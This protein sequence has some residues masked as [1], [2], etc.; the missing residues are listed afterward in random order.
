MSTRVRPALSEMIRQFA[1][2]LRQDHARDAD[3]LSAFAHQQDDQAF[4]DLVA[5]HGP[6]VWGVC[7]RGLIDPNDAEDAFQATFL[8]LARQAGA[9][10]ERAR[11]H[12]TLAGWLYLTAQRIAHNL[13]R[14]QA[15]RC[16]HEQKAAAD[17]SE[18]A[19]APASPAF[20]LGGVLDEELGQLPARFREPLVLC[21]FQGKT[22][23][24]AA[25]QLGCPVGTVSGRLARACE[26]LR[27]RLARRGVALA[28]GQVAVVLAAAGSTARAAV[29]PVPAR[30]ADA[31]A[32]AAR[33]F[34][35]GD[36][37]GTAAG[38]LA[39]GVP[40]VR[41]G[42]NIKFV[43][44][45]AVAFLGVTVAAAVGLGPAP[46]PPADVRSASP[47]EVRDGGHAFGDP[48]PTGAIARLGTLR[49][50]TGRMGFTSSV[51]F[52]PGAKS[53]LSAH[54]D[55]VVH[56]WD[57]VTGR[58][59]PRLD[60]PRL[61]TAVSATPD[62]RRL[63]G[64]GAS[65]VW[66]WDL[67]ANPP[68]V[69][70]KTQQ[71]RIVRGS[72]AI[73]PNGRLVAHGSVKGTV[74]LLDAATGDELRTF[75]AVGSGLT[76]APDSM[77]LAAWSHESAVNASVA[78]TDVSVWNV[79]DGAH[80]YTLQVAPKGGAVSAVAFSPDGT[81]VA[82]AAGDRRLRLWNAA[83]GT[84]RADLTADADPLAYVGFQ[85]DGTLIEAGGGRVRF[86]DTVRGA[87][88]RP[89]V[90]AEDT[91]DAYLLSGDGTLLAR[92]GLFGAGMREVATGREIGA[93]A[94]M[95]DGLVHAVAFAPDGRSVVTAAYSESA[96]GSLYL[97]DATDG[98]LRG[99]AGTGTGHI[100]WGLDIAPDG[101][102]SVASVPLYRNPAPRTRVMTWAEGL[103]RPPASYPLP[104]GTRCGASSPDRRYVAAA[105]GDRVVFCDRATGQEVRAL[106]IKCQANSL[107]FSADGS[108]V[109]VL[110]VSARRVTVCS[111]VDG[112]QTAW[113][114]DDGA[115]VQFSL[116]PLALSPDG[117]LFAVCVAGRD[118]R[119]RV[120]ETA[121]GAEL[122]Q[123]DAR[124]SGLPAP[125]FV[126]SPDGRTLAA[127]G[128]DGT[129]RV[130]E[131]ATG[132]ERYRFSGHRAGVFSVAYSPDSRRVASASYD[133]TALVW[134]VG[135]LPAVPKNR[136]A[137][138]ELW[139]ALTG[140]EAAPAY[141]AI[142][143]LVDSPGVAVPLLR[144]KLA[145]PAAPPARVREWLADLGSN[146]FATREAASRE[147]ARRGD[148]VFPEL[149]QA[150]AAAGSPEVRA[151]L[152]RLLE[153][154]GSLSPDSRAVVRGVEVLERLG[155]D[156]AARELL[157]ELAGAP[158]E[159]L[160]GRESRAAY[161]RLVSATAQ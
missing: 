80:E 58:E 122:W 79:A 108:C 45:L 44:V 22:H 60:A 143:A 11:T 82:T 139:A 127:A 42:V 131:V 91:A 134:D 46:T 147:L 76:F 63:V 38:Q 119:L 88:S 97:W 112:R 125:E 94:G 43:G 71:P 33:P 136:A 159:S 133:C 84:W 15:R 149:K 90:R 12:E 118:G 10:A 21:Y 107:A 137:P 29:A 129:V 81:T 116:S 141:R 157:R 152:R 105:T 64:V 24:D 3:L 19:T 117:R 48:L 150:L 103:G 74:V 158:T 113:P 5:R 77:R 52:G 160:L 155:A 102:V 142:A 104:A 89:P 6:L 28:V 140:H 100:I 128:R 98:K 109:G 85:P 59:R 111:L 26:L 123:A 53:L 144:S 101:A 9:L 47:P 13:R 34:V 16:E 120:I 110:D 41:A 23:A 161:R 73:S 25:R 65:E 83:D 32:A 115:A 70:W 37:A 51:A 61:C 138:E 14:S 146:Q 56:V 7:S 132:E 153:R 69:L 40:P 66:A 20:E 121:T 36:G 87:Q 31:T 93:G 130:W 35:T 1:G 78:V 124:L 145:P 30:L 96:G 68:A 86:W 106:P 2:G 72:I 8:A 17:W 50:R 75:P 95:P 54:G 49:F 148:Q 92:A 18:R 67:A 4:A 27:D 151:R 39:L 135:T 154:L 55:D 114:R 57:P 156:P 126:F 99:Q 62:G